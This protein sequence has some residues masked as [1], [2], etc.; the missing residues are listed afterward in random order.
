MTKPLCPSCLFRSP[1]PGLSVCNPCRDAIY[2]AYRLEH[3]QTW[4]SP[5]GNLKH[6][7][8]GAGPMDSFPLP[9]IPNERCESADPD[10]S[11]EMIP[12]LDLFTN[13]LD[14][15]N[16]SNIPFGCTVFFCPKCLMPMDAHTPE[17]G[18]ITFICWE[19]FTGVSDQIPALALHTAGICE[20]GDRRSSQ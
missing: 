16:E 17:G 15:I 13:I 12:P 6:H 18:N 1:A 19:C 11:E 20:E 5:D 10:D 4:E 8:L 7:E 14:G 2:E 9:Y 3:E